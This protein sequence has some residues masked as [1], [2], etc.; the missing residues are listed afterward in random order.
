[1]ADDTVVCPSCQALITVTSEP[2]PLAGLCEARLNTIEA[3]LGDVYSR[4]E[5][6]IAGVNLIGQQNN[7][8]TEVVTDFGMKFRD[9]SPT[10]LLKGVLFGSGNGK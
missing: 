8:M 3:L 5:K 9:A 4:L 6:L 1:M 10:Q 2:E 7:A